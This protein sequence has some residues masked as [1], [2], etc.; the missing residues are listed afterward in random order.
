MITPSGIHIAFTT[1]MTTL[2]IVLSI[3]LVRVLFYYK[4]VKDLFSSCSTYQDNSIRRTNGELKISLCKND[5]YPFVTDDE[6]SELFEIVIDNGCYAIST[7]SGVNLDTGIFTKVRNLIDSSALIAVY[8][9]ETYKVY[10]PDDVP[11]MWEEIRTEEDDKYMFEII[12]GFVTGLLS[13]VGEYC[14]IHFSPLLNEVNTVE[15]MLDDDEELNDMVNI[16]E[17]DLM[18]LDNFD[19]SEEELSEG[20]E[21]YHSECELPDDIFDN[22]DVKESELPEFGIVDEMIDVLNQKDG[23]TECSDTAREMIGVLVNRQEEQVRNCSPLSS[24]E[25]PYEYQLSPEEQE[26][27]DRFEDLQSL[28]FCSLSSFDEQQEPTHNWRPSDGDEPCVDSSSD[29]EEMG[30][31]LFD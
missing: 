31:G 18:T 16:I 15:D 7:V 8:P 22:Y 1:I 14:D 12:D 29:G 28:G 20:T 17:D 23:E 19:D 24:D 26:E 21:S 3:A 25:E 27:E 5:Y 10:F 6:P 2:A 11:G 30:Y 9:G 4:Q 13:S